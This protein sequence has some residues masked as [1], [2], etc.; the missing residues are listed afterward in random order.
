MAKK[1]ESPCTG[2]CQFR[3]SVCVGCGR[4]KMEIKAWHGMNR[5]ERLLTGKRAGQRLGKLKR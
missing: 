4:D 3:G 2:V 1:I 5:K